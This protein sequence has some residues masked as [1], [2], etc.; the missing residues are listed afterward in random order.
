[1]AQIVKMRKKNNDTLLSIIN[2][3]G[4]SAEP[5]ANSLIKGEYLHEKNEKL[6][7]E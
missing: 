1:M 6:R 7:E 5:L 4:T 2:E 3:T